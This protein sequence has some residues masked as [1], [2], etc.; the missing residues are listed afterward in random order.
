[1]GRYGRIIF[2]SLMLKNVNDIDQTELLTRKKTVRTPRGV[3]VLTCRKVHQTLELQPCY[4]PCRGT[5]IFQS[6]HFC[7]KLYP[8]AKEEGWLKK[9]ELKLGLLK[10]IT[11]KTHRSEGLIKQ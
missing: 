8:T 9:K 1:M 6:N 11:G 4:L 2:S 3:S 7:H 5:V 10:G